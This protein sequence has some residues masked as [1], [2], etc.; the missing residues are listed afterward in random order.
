[1]S[2]DNITQ[3]PDLGPQLTGDIIKAAVEVHRHLGSGLLESV[4][5]PCFAYELKQLGLQVERQVTLP[6]Q[7]KELTI[8]QGLKI[9]LWVNRKVI[10]ELKACEKII[11]VYRAQLVS[12]MRLS[13]T[14][15]G[16][17][18][19]FNEKMITKGIERMALTEFS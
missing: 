19:N 9:D 3:F 4:Y 13:K 2:E 5:E 8:E 17:L 15:L 14:P 16:L 18:I 10:V 1:M 11:P 12:Y 6:I 7:Y